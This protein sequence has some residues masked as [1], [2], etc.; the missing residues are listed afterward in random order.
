MTSDGN[1]VRL[2]RALT[3]E[4]RGKIGGTLTAVYDARTEALHRDLLQEVPGMTPARVMNFIR[5]FDADPSK[6]LSKALVHIIRWLGVF[7]DKYTA[8]D[9]AELAT[10]PFYTLSDDRTLWPSSQRDCMKTLRD[11]PW[12]FANVGK[13]ISVVAREVRKVAKVGLGETDAHAAFVIARYFME[14]QSMRSSFFPRALDEDPGEEARGGGGMYEAV[15]SLVHDATRV[16]QGKIEPSLLHGCVLKLP[17]LEESREGA[18]TYAHPGTWPV[19]A[20]NTPSFMDRTWPH[21]IYVDLFTTLPPKFVRDEFSP[22]AA[23]DPLLFLWRIECFRYQNTSLFT[24]VT[25]LA[26]KFHLGLQGDLIL[27]WLE[28]LPLRVRNEVVETLTSNP[29]SI[30]HEPFCG[31]LCSHIRALVGLGIRDGELARNIAEGL[32]RMD[33]KALENIG[34]NLDEFCAGED[35]GKR[36]KFLSEWLAFFLTSSSL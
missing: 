24:H 30:Y 13:V 12:Y 9:L 35:E 3:L 19:R 25:A 7:S 14:R 5:T 1:R 31:S 27:S 22:R 4:S 15:A 8:E 10:E 6:A 11:R 18:W 23:D 21:Q 26:R 17:V 32:G 28:P 34:R 16:L 36:G 33:R 2:A 20:P 29:S